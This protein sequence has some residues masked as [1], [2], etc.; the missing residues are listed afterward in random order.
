MPLSEGM[1]QVAARY[2]AFVNKVGILMCPT[3]N[4]SCDEST[5]N[6]VDHCGVQH[7]TTIFNEYFY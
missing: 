1:R 6:G 3:Y 5:G 4:P 7:V 2:I